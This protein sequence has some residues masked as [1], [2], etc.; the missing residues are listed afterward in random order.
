MNYR[1]VFA[2]LACASA[3]LPGVAVAQDT[4]L[5]YGTSSAAM[6]AAPLLLATQEPDIFGEHGIQ[7]AMTDFRGQTANCVV[8]VISGAV[9][10][11]Q[12]GTLSGTDAIAEGAPLVSIG[13]TNAMTA[14]LIMSEHAVKRSGLTVDSPLGDKLR[15][16]EGLRLIS[17]APGT[18]H[19][20]VLNEM[21]KTVDLSLDDTEYR[22]LGDTM[23][24]ME[25]LRNDA[26]DAVLRSIGGLGP[27]LADGSGIRWV[28]P[29]TD[30]AEL[31]ELP[32]Y[33]V[34]ARQEWV[35]EN[36]ELVASIR[37][38][39]SV[40]IDRIIGNPDETG[41]VIK[42]AYF[43]DMD[44]AIWDDGFI[45]N[46]KTLIPGAAVSKEGWR[47]YLSLYIPTSGK[48]YDGVTFESVVVPSARAE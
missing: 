39:L 18:G 23:A 11:C 16:L 1:N 8:A 46:V 2:T 38:A 7:V 34:Y 44:Q 12:V 3:I 28:S 37:A 6:V 15:A 19:Y 13:A 25:S 48:S 14:E 33:I 26:V 17:S 22:V 47:K 32:Y 10:L 40:A 41:A 29:R 43:P 4:V 27:V 35:A 30:M 21:L 31:A 36:P 24:M 20:L 9:D 45:E 5:K 42:A